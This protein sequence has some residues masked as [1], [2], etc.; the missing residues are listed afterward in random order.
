LV[1][2]KTTA[3]NYTLRDL[4]TLLKIG[5]KQKTYGD[6]KIVPEFP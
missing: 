2:Q 5:K 4:E 1:T 3:I 6:K